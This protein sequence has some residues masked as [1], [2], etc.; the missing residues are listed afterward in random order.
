MRLTGVMGEA[1]EGAR[2]VSVLC[3]SKEQVEICTHFSPGMGIIHQ[4]EFTEE[5]ECGF[6]KCLC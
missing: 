1:S 5:E 3:L 6:A 4:G 2:R